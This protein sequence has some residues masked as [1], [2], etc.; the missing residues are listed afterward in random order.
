MSS[1]KVCPFCKAPKLPRS[2]DHYVC[3]SFRTLW[4]H[5]QSKRCRR[6]QKI[7]KRGQLTRYVNRKGETVITSLDDR[8]RDLVLHFRKQGIQ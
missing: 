5:V 8:L 4:G 7:R 6:Y 2:L 1:A 3:F